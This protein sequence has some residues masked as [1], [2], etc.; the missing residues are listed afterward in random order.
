[1]HA[2]EEGAIVGLALCLMPQDPREACEPTTIRGV[3][4]RGTK[5]H[6]SWFAPGGKPL[7]RQAA[8]QWVRSRSASP[9]RAEQ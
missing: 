5:R 9:T 2:V 1:M 3:A 4:Q 8:V 6:L 7:A